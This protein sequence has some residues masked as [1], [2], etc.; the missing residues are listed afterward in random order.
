MKAT[1]DDIEYFVGFLDVRTYYPV[2]VLDAQSAVQRDRTAV[3]VLPPRSVNST[4]LNKA[5]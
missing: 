4:S 3:W 1:A 2:R 5:M